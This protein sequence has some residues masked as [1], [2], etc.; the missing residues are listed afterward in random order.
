MNCAQVLS[1][2]SI[3]EGYNNSVFSDMILEGKA[4]VF[5]ENLTGNDLAKDYLPTRPFEEVS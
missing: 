1:A 3:E 2:K 5:V 4:Y